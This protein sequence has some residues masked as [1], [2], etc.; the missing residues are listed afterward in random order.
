MRRLLR[1]L[2]EARPAAMSR[3]FGTALLVLLTLTFAA[4]SAEASRADRY[5]EGLNDPAAVRSVYFVRGMACRACTMLVD[6]KLNREEGIYWAVVHDPGKYSGV[7]LEKFIAEP[8]ELSLALLGSGPAAS[9][10]YRKGDPVVTWTG[11]SLSLE[12]ARTSSR[13]FEETILDFGIKK[14]SEDWAQVAYEIA[15]EEARNR[16]ILAMALAGGFDKGVVE[17]EILTVVAKDFY[18]P[19]ELLPPTADESAMARVLREKVMLGDESEAGRERF[20]DWLL[21]LWQEIALDFKGEA[22]ELTGVRP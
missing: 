20:D 19:T 18:W 21:G 15:A 10:L 11:G 3:F 9:F 4:P 16:I 6:R 1:R 5:R 17:E 14:G 2:L 7:A 8:G 13:P 22:L 12:E